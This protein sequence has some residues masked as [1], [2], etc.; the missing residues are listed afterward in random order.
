MMTDRDSNSQEQDVS[1][2]DVMKDIKAQGEL[3]AN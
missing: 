1:Q 3:N 2:K